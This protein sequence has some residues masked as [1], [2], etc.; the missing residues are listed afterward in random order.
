VFANTLGD[1][2]GLAHIKEPTLLLQNV[3]ALL[4]E[5]WWHTEYVAEK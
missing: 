5:T 4:K 3:D 1:I 2:S